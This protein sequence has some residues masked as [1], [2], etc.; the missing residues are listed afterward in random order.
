MVYKR[1]Y[2]PTLATRLARWNTYEWLMKKKERHRRIAVKWCYRNDLFGP[3][4]HRIPSH[5]KNIVWEYAVSPSEAAQFVSYFRTLVPLYSVKKM[6]DV[7]EIWTFH[8]LH[9]AE[10]RRAFIDSL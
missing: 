10:A 2:F 8:G 1:K 9:R 6:L 5:I 3:D 7:K 4:W